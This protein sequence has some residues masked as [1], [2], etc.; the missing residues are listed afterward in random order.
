MEAAWVPWKTAR[1]PETPG[2]DVHVNLKTFIVL[3]H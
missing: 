3:G 1:Q 2:L